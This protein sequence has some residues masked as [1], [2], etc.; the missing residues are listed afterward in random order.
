MYG[1]GCCRTRLKSSEEATDGV[2]APANRQSW[3]ISAMDAYHKCTADSQT[4]RSIY[5]ACIMRVHPRS[6]SA[7]PFH[8][9]RCAVR[10][11]RLQ[12]WRQGYGVLR[13]A[14]SRSHAGRAQ[15]RGQR[16]HAGVALKQSTTLMT[17]V[18]ARSAGRRCAGQCC[19]RPCSRAKQLLKV[20]AHA[21]LAPVRTAYVRLTLVVGVI[22][23]P[24]LGQKQSQLPCVPCSWRP[25][26]R[27]CWR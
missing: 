23:L 24:C 26:G 21:C 8:T 5:A 13:A 7:C 11:R 25:C 10:R 1:A 17:C 6:S 19:G 20:P 2:I 18:Q 14:G 16:R 3:N 12:L 22:K 15:P 27:A 9:D 4:L